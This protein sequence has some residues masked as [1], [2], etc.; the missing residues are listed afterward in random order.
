[1]YLSSLTLE[2]FKSYAES[3][4][5]DFS[6]EIAVIVGSNGVGKSNALDGILWALGEDNTGTLRCRDYHDLL[7]AGSENTPA[8]DEASAQLRFRENGSEFTIRR[9][10]HRSGE[11]RFVVL[12][13]PMKT[14]LEYES[15]LNRVGLENARKNVIRQE[16]LTDFFSLG[17]ED[18]VRLFKSY[19]AN[20]EDLELVK[21]NFQTY[22]GTMI[23]DSTARLMGGLDGDEVD[24]EV[25][26]PDKG[27]KAGVLLSSGE[28]AVTALA[29]KLALFQLKP[30]PMYLLDEVEPYLDWARNNNMQGL[31]KT[32][33]TDRQLIMITHL[34]STIQMADTVHGVRVRSDGSSWLKFHFKMDERLIR[35]YRCC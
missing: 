24:V 11:E 33:S 16:Q 8:A 35:I 26:F 9:S 1:M 3:V 7:Y 14:L 19:V 23:P 10:L 22:L 30:S 13:K 28:R 27:P 6:S 4:E 34:R 5:V 18:R 20:A 17:A 12:D 32:L 31:L 29:L 21:R 25:A 2:G 15:A